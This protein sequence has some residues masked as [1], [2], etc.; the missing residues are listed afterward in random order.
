MSKKSILI[1][2]PQGCGKT[3]N[4]AALAAAYGFKKSCEGDTGLF[5]RTEHLIVGNPIVPKKKPADTLPLS[6]RRTVLKEWMTRARIHRW[7][8]EPEPPVKVRK[9]KMVMDEWNTHVDALRERFHDE[10][11]AKLLEIETALLL[12]DFDK[13]AKLL[14]GYRDMM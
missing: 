11:R 13:F 14:I 10:R 6:L 7:F 3:L 12:N 4:A 1:V 5:P 2:G 8:K 9:A